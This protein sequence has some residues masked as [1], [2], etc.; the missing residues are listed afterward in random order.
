MAPEIGNDKPDR[1]ITM[2]VKYRLLHVT[3]FAQIDT[4]VLG[5]IKATTPYESAIYSRADEVEAKRVLK[6][7][8]NLRRVFLAIEKKINDSY[9]NNSDV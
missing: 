8:L 9:A 4:A 6:V 2:I 1:E 3:Q 7:A 5:V